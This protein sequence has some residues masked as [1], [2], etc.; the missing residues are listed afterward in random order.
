MHS[1]FGTIRGYI[2]DE[3]VFIILVVILVGV[4]SFGLGRLSVESAAPSQAVEQT[5]ASRESFEQA[6]AATGAITTDP[7]TVVVEVI[8]AG[9][10]YVASK[11]GTKYHLPSCPGA[12]QMSEA[13]KIYF[14]SKE[15]AA[16]AGYQPAA[17]CKGL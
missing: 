4:A 8:P 1:F 13:N 6:A 3:T 17:N 15:E 14:A 11:N 9:G 16:S 7:E 2:M 10:S 12:K 5:Y